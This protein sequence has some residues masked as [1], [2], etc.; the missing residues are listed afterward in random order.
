MTARLVPFLEGEAP[1]APVHPD[2]YI[3][4]RVPKAP[5]PDGSIVV[6]L[7]DGT[8]LALNA[9]FLMRLQPQPRLPGS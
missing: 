1:S 9:R 3:P 8:A 5:R 2:A 7:T 4:V 6:Y